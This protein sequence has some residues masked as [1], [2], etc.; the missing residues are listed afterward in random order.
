[1]SNRKV[2]RSSPLTLRTEVSLPKKS[3]KPKSIL[4]ESKKTQKTLY[5]VYYNG[6]LVTPKPLNPL[7]YRE[8]KERQIS[9]LNIADNAITTTF[10]SKSKSSIFGSFSET[11]SKLHTETL[12]NMG[13]TNLYTST[14]IDIALLEPLVDNDTLSIE[15]SVVI[16]PPPRLE[17]MP[18]K[19]SLT[20]VETPTIFLFEL[21]SSTAEADTVEGDLVESDNKMYEYLTVGK[22]RNRKV[23]CAEVQTIPV[24]LK[25]RDTTA[26]R[27]RT[28]SDYAY[29]S[30]WDMYDTYNEVKDEDE[31]NNIPLAAKES[32]QV[33]I[34]SFQVPSEE[35]QMMALVKTPE[36]LNALCVVERLL[37]NNNFNAQQKRFRGLSD[38]DPFR[39]K[40]EY[41]YELNLLWT[42]ANE[43]TAGRCATTM[44]WNPSNQDILAVGYGKFYYSERTTGLVMIWNIKNPVQPERTYNFSEPVTAVDFSK[45]HP[46]VLAI[47]F[48]DGT[49][50]VI[51]ISDHELMV[52]GESSREDSPIFEP[53]WQLTWYTDQDY[54]KGIEFLMVASQDGRLSRFT[55]EQA[56][57]MP[58]FHLMRVSRAEGRIKGLKST[59]KCVIPGIPIARHPAS[60]V[61][62]E[63]PINP[64]IYYV[65]TS[66]GVI[67]KCSK[68]YY[69][70]HLD[71]FLGHEGPI[72]Q[73]KFSPFCNKVFLTCGDDWVVRIWAEGIS[74]PL[75]ELGK[76]MLSVQGADWCPAFST[77]IASITGNDIFLWDLQRKVYAPQSV[78]K[79][80]TKARCTLVEF[81][82]SGRCL[83]VGDIEGNIMI[84]SL[85]DMPFQAFYQDKLLTQAIKRELVIVPELARKVEKLDG[86]SYKREKSTKNFQ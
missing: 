21:S 2:S 12:A 57:Y 67:H 40:I 72:Y 43:K 10:S 22:G 63:H 7:I 9:I 79:S 82:Q 80:P 34:D 32:V 35:K 13:S 65:G 75:L 58:Y 56:S 61:M 70:Q 44:C 45:Q 37:A 4:K 15:G 69:H 73:F 23:V 8:G 47:G 51:E 46:N 64:N 1:M 5:P 19:V 33:S 42:F 59:R 11:S 84:F 25:T 27:Y 39:E 60:L 62:T 53:I 74:T 30:G 36:F 52:L 77:I 18:S 28:K 71:L 86:L 14:N 85:E 66:E 78:T 31:E 16:A 17:P 3:A 76:T 54:Y 6:E 49:I 38:P 20:L 41:K 68:N 24:L 29:A 81:T 55:L 26:V 83:V 48:Y 50:K